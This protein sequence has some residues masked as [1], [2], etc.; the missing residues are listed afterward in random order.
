MNPSTVISNKLA[1]CSRLHWL[2]GFCNLSSHTI[3]ACNCTLPF[4]QMFPTLTIGCKD[5]ILTRVCLFSIS[6]DNGCFNRLPTISSFNFELHAIVG[7]IFRNLELGFTA[8]GI[9]SFWLNSWILILSSTSNFRT[10]IITIPILISIII[11]IVILKPSIFC[12]GIITPFVLSSLYSITID[13]CRIERFQ[14]RNSQFDH[15]AWRNFLLIYCSNF[16]GA[17]FI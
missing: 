8:F 2:I 15:I 10:V 3:C 16:K 14:F 7:F 12:I 17:V 6:H 13:L 1:F 11:A 4:G 9:N 5:S